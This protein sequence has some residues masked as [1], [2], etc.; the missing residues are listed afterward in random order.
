M[1]LFSLIESMYTGRNI[2]FG[3]VNRR[4]L[5]GHLK[6]IITGRMLVLVATQFKPSPIREPTLTL[7]I[8]LLLL[9]ENLS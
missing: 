3:S 5:S 6:Y 7:I 2:L 8:I 4:S 9:A 1:V